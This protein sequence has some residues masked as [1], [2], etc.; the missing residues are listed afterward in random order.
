MAATLDKADDNALLSAAL[1]AAS[2]VGLELLGL[3]LRGV[4][5]LP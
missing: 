5:R 1:L 2:C 3:R 4:S